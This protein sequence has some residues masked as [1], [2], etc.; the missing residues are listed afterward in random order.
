MGSNEGFLNL[1]PLNLE[2][3]ESR[4]APIP[5]GPPGLQYGRLSNGLVYYVR[6]NSKPKQRAALAL[7]VRVGSVHEEDHERGV[8]HIIE[9]LAFRSTESYLNHD[10][11]KF[12][13]SIG[14]KFGACQNA[15]TSED[16]TVFELFV[17]IDQPKLLAEALSVLAEFSTE[18]RITDDDL[19]KERGAVLEEWRER[20]NA[21]GRMQEAH[22]NLVMQGMKY[23]ERSPIGL[24]KVI[25]NVSATTVRSF[26]RRWYRLDRMAIVAVGD[27]EDPKTVVDLIEKLFGSKKSRTDDSPVAMS[28]EALE[29]IE[30]EAKFVPHET[31]RYSVTSEKEAPGSAVMLSC[32]MPNKDRITLDD[33]RSLLVEEMFHMALNQRFFKLSRQKNPPFY[34]CQSSSQVLARPINSYMMSATVQDKGTV[35]ALEAMLTELARARLHGFSEREIAQ[36]R[37]QYMADVESAYAEREQI[38]SQ[39]LRDEYMQHF[40]R[41]EPVPGIE[42]EAQL[43]KTLLPVITLDEVVEVAKQYSLRESCVIKVVEHRARA[44]TEKLKAVVEKVEERERLGLIEPWQGNDVPE[45][46]VVTKP[47]PGL[48][49]STTYLKEALVTEMVLSNGMKVC[50]KCTDF[51]DDQVLINGYAYGGLSNVPESD[52]HSCSMST[53]IAG[54]IGVFGFK[55]DVLVDMLGGKRAEVGTKIGAYMRTFSGECSPVDFETQLKLVYQLFVTS[56]TPVEEDLEVVMQMTEEA[57][58]AQER[59]PFTAYANRVR[60]LNYGDSY[61]FKPV[62]VADLSKVDPVK[63]CAY[64]DQCFKE[65]SSFTVVI[66]GNM[67]QEQALPLILM[68]LGGIPKPSEP[69]PQYQ[70]DELQ[71]L[72]FTF[73]QGVVREEVLKDMVEPQCSTQITFPVDLDGTNVTDEVHWTGLVCRLLE[74]KIL[75]ELRFEHGRVY[76]VSVSA[77]LGGSRPSRVGGVR[78]DIA[79]SFSCDPENTWQLVDDVLDVVRK[80]QQDGPSQADIDTILEVE[81]RS[82][83]TGLQENGFWLDRLLRAYQSR[84]YI[85]DLRASFQAQE[86]SWIRVMRSAAVTENMKAA[87]RRI[88]PNPCTEHY[89]GVCLLPRP[90]LWRRVWKFSSTGKGSYGGRFTPETTGLFIAVVIGAVAATALVVGVLWK[91]GRRKS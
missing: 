21:F 75:Q 80:L 35:R 57:I 41:N 30:A 79:V 15:H 17:P 76:T 39:N 55:P 11:V 84:L 29:S 73:P 24:E 67:N 28:L 25:R 88:L 1:K 18:I 58:K 20:R 13:E 74:T 38:P 60:S 23:A 2:T 6:K 14:A 49:V 42:F 9:H 27:F 53:T 46:L 26:Y 78:G 40:L 4:S 68:Y 36:V 52:F 31:P 34:S 10:I 32:K 47:I 45:D 48:M 82:Y 69:I 71:P 83:E 90:P 50:L 8:A 91:S 3:V 16:D 70:R 62:T 77:F 72:P 54:E 33:F 51:S 87:L 44:T 56:V 86:D 59:N 66:V 64:F 19:D 65:P 85:G 37:S 43:V 22:W 89:T 81:K 7:G 5:L 63:S 61:Y 12:L